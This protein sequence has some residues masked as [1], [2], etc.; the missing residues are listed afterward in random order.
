MLG[1]RHYITFDRRRFSFGGHCAHT[2][3]Q[4]RAAVAAVVAVALAAVVAMVLAAVVGT[5]PE[6]GLSG[7]SAPPGLC[8]GAAAD[9]G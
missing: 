4:V 3:V 5:C 8:G 7:V 1:G 6:L 9:R 2:L